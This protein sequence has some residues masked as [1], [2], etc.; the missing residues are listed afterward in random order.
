MGESI[1]RSP[2][3]RASNVFSAQDIPNL[4]EDDTVVFQ[5]EVRLFSI[6]SD[7]IEGQDLILP[8]CVK[9]EKKVPV[10]NKCFFKLSKTMHSGGSRLQRQKSKWNPNHIKFDYKE[11]ALRKT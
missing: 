5:K 2:Y 9:L 11:D 4:E 6:E 7:I 8:L 1:F 3:S 10:S